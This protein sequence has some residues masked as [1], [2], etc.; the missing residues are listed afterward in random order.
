[1]AQHLY[2]IPGVRLI[3]ATPLHRESWFEPRRGNTAAE[4]RGRFLLWARPS[5]RAQSLPREQRGEGQLEARHYFSG[6]GR[7]IF[8]HPAAVRHRFYRLLTNFVGDSII[9][10]ILKR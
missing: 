3:V 1:M 8:Y 10:V 7:P 9:D 6:V 4:K 5:A 2:R